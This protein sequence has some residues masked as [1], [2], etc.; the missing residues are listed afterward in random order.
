MA[1]EEAKMVC[2]TRFVVDAPE[3]SKEGDV[4]AEVRSSQTGL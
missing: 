3:N 1:V 4:A 2:P